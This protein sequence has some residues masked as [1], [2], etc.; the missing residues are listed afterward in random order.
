MEQWSG[1]DSLTSGVSPQNTYSDSDI[2]NTLNFKCVLDVGVEAPTKAFI[3]HAENLYAREINERISQDLRFKD[4]VSRMMAE[5]RYFHRYLKPS[6][7][8]AYL[9]EYRIKTHTASDEWLSSAHLST[10]FLEQHQVMSWVHE[11]KNLTVYR[12]IRE[13]FPWITVHAPMEDPEETIE[14]RGDSPTDSYWER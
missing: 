9:V 1:L 14:A 6:E 2:G 8:H 11:A 13:R 5:Q 3:K 4:T 10:R 12:W 7:R